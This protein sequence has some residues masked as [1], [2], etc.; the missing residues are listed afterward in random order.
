M[1][2]SQAVLRT[3][4]TELLAAQANPR[5]NARFERFDREFVV[6]STIL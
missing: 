1:V 6:H 4:Q 2:S 5:R 3:S